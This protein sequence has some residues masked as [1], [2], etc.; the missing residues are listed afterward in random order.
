MFMHILLAVTKQLNDSLHS[1]Y[2]QGNSQR[3]SRSC[4]EGIFVVVA[5]AVGWTALGNSAAQMFNC[6]QYLVTA[7]CSG[8]QG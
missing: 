5:K 6:Q 8:D 3:L 4:R 2:L 7:T 1:F